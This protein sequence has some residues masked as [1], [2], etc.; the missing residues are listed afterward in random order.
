MNDFDADQVMRAANDGADLVLSGFEVT[1]RET[2]LVN[3]VVNAIS[4]CLTNPNATLDDV[5]SENYETDL[6]EIRG[7]WDW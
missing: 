7:W 1:D 5:V 4:T 6:D 2:D 3:L